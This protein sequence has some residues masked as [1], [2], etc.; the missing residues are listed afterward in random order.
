MPDHNRRCTDKK[1]FLNKWQMIVV[2]VLSTSA[3][4]GLIWAKAI[5]PEIDSMIDKKQEPIY[6]ALEY[7][8]CLHMAFMTQE[9]I[10]KATV[11]YKQSRLCKGKGKK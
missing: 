7:N 5:A 9:Q 2:S 11:L 3:L 6:D 1:K 4:V 8:N 10:D